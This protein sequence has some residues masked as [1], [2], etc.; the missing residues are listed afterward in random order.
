[1]LNKLVTAEKR[2]AE[3]EAAVL[4]LSD[5]LKFADLAGFHAGV[6]SVYGQAV[7]EDRGEI[8]DWMRGRWPAAL[9]KLETV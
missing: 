3:L 5:P 8:A 2:I 7:H 9:Q 1:M 6:R 4:V